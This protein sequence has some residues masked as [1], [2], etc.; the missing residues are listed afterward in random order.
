MQPKT[1]VE[2]FTESERKLLRELLK[3]TEVDVRILNQIK[4]NKKLYELSIDILIQK[5]NKPTEIYNTI[6]F[7]NYVGLN[8]LTP[9]QKI[10][11]GKKL[12][13]ELDKLSTA[14]FGSRHGPNYVIEITK[15]LAK[16]NTKIREIDLEIYLRQALHLEAYYD[17]AF[18]KVVKELI[19]LIKVSDNPTEKKARERRVGE[20]LIYEYWQS[21]DPVKQREFLK[22]YKIGRKFG[23]FGVSKPKKKKPQNKLLT[24]KRRK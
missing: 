7:L 1:N 18:G 9:I 19:K 14:G 10:E 23:A 21:F 12:K 6:K 13:I 11:L 3:N 22:Q 16:L 24:Q 4:L 8:N 20:T 5:M 17:E 15:T 2:K